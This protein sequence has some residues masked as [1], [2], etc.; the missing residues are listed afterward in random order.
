M[1]L[2]KKN[3]W[4][5]VAALAVFLVFSSAFTPPGKLDGGVGESLQ[6]LFY[7]VVFG[8]DIRSPSSVLGTEL[9]DVEMEGQDEIQIDRPLPSAVA[10]EVEKV[11]R[12]PLPT[13]EP[14]KSYKILIYHTHND[15]SYLRQGEDY[16][17]TT[18]GRTYNNEYNVVHIG[19]ILAEQLTRAGFTVV[20]DT[21][22]NVSAGFYTA[23]NRS[24]DLVKQQVEKNGPFDLVIDL[25]RD[26]YNPRSVNT[27]TVNGLEAARVMLIIGTAEG[28]ENNHFS[29]KPDWRYNLAIANALNAELNKMAENLAKKVNIKTNRYNQHINRGSVLIEVGNNQNTLPEAE[30]TASLLAKALCAYFGVEDNG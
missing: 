18:Q 24:L 13:P 5:A 29:V 30:Y 27:V 22:D 17:E 7:Q 26:A 25:H 15:E 9:T 8:A 20:H 12:Q 1:G 11:N 2:N 23:Y 19:S 16:K 28:D 10:I 3:R 21:S 14:K 4:M 6:S